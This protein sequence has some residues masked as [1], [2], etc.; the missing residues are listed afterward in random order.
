MGGPDAG[1]LDWRGILADVRAHLPPAQAAAGA[2]RGSLRWLEAEMRA[3]GANPA[4]VRNI[5]YRDIGTPADKTALV[6]I[7]TDL[8]REA[9]RPPPTV[10]LPAAPARLPDELELLGRSKKRAYKQFLAG[11]RAG[12]MPRMIVTG[13]RGAGKTVLLDHLALALTAE[14]VPVLRLSLAGDVAAQWPAP[15]AAGRSFAALAAAQAEAARAA[16]V[17]REGVL[18]ARVT[19]DLNW[20]AEPPRLPDGTPVSAA[21]WATEHL[22]R[23][24]PAGLAVVLALEDAAGVE[25]HWPAGGAELIELHPPTPAEARAYLMARLGIGR[26]AADALVRETGRNLDRLTLLASV[27]RGE[28]GQG[29]S[30][31]ARLL[32]DPD[33]RALAAALAGLSVVALPDAV[34]DAALCAALGSPPA[35]LPAHARALLSGSPALGWTPADVLLAALPLVPAAEAQAA[36][37]RLVAVFEGHEQETAPELSGFSLAA[38]TLLQDWPAL[39]AQISRRP[40]DARHLPPLWAAIRGSRDKSGASAEAL[41]ILARALATHHAGRGEYGDPRARDALFTLL[42]SPRDPVRAWARVKLAES[43]VDAGNFEAARGQ[44]AHPDLT[45][46]LSE[47]SA[48]WPASSWTVAAQADA[49]L[50]QAALARWS[51]DLEAATRAAGDPRTAQGGPRA[52]LWRGLIAKDAGHWPEALSALQSVPPSSPLLSARA[53]YQEGDLRLRLG[54]PAAALRALEDAAERLPRAGGSAEETARVLARAATAQRRLGH[55]QE[56]LTLL[57]RALGLISSP[58]SPQETRPQDSRPRE[59]ALPRARLLSEGLPI[60]LALGRPDEA[61]AQAAAALGLLSGVLTVSGSRQAEAEY[62][63][64]RTQYR[65][66]LAYL[67]RG[68]GLPYLYPFCGPRRDHP[69]LA[70]ARTLLDRLLRPAVDSSQPD[71]EQV[72]TFDMLLTRALADPAPAPALHFAERALAMTDHAY[73]AAQAHAI[74]AEAHLRADRTGSAL[75]DINRAHTMLRRV[76]LGVGGSDPLSDTHAADPGLAAQL[77]ALEVRATI[78]EGA[79]A[80]LWLRTALQDPALHPFRAGVWRE[81]GRALEAHHPGAAGELQRIY[82]AARLARVDALR[83]R[84][85]LWVLE[86]E[87]GLQD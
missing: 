67:T 74:R 16:L 24:A 44:L 13:R 41:E 71:R 77:L 38:L 52:A 28:A 7:L 3:R 58:V 83:V 61:L 6:A 27:G 84:D 46:L 21:V 37:R 59:D 42:E 50:V 32:A 23:R 12:R 49:L 10:S 1:V 20:A 5:V 47:S 2:V 87:T 45:H 19:T 79:G 31:A 25:A 60:L 54:Q 8:A 81:A 85:R 35:A 39:A 70:Q 56:G 33:I 51:G 68:I 43:S 80:L 65:L 29:E 15:P 30:G 4:S 66:A 82:P 72:L 62:R 22:L 78:G 64:R 34:P 26:A 53:R 9:G 40:D 36:A 55:P 76:A 48:S 73:A 18:L 57:G 63:L 86:S 69:D 11:V 75:A 17:G 14:G